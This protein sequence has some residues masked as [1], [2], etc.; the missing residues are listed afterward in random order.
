MQYG[1][2]DDQNFEYVI[3]KPDTPRPWTNYLGSTKYG[4]IITNHAGGFSF[5]KSAKNGR[6]IRFRANNIP[7]DQPGRYFYIRDQES[8]DFWSS[9]WQP[10]GKDLT[11]YMSICRHGTAYT[12][13]ESE[14]DHIFSESSYFVPLHKDYECWILKLVNKGNKKRKLAVFTY[15]EF[16]SHWNL[17]ADMLNLQYSQYIVNTKIIDNILDISIHNNLPFNDEAP[18]KNNSWH[19]FFTIIGAEITGYDTDREEV[20]GVY[21]GYHNPK[22]LF[23]G[24]CHNNTSQGDNACATM[25]VDIILKPGESKEFLVVMG[26]G[27]AQ[28]AGKEVV[29]SIRDVSDAGFELEKLKEY[30]HSMIGNF[31]TDTPDNNFNSTVNVWGAY[32]CLITYAWSRAASFVYQGERNGLGYRDTVQDMMGVLCNIPEEAVKRLELMI[33]GQ[34]RTG[35]ALPVVDPF[36]HFPGEMTAPGKYRSD[37]CL[38][39][40]NAVPEYVKET[41]DM[42]FYYKILP[43]ADEG[44]DTV[45]NHLKKALEFNLHLVGQNNLPCVMQADWNDCI[46]LGYKGESLFTAMQVSYGLKEY[47]DIC[48]RLNLPD[49]VQW[50]KKELTPLDKAILKTGWDGNWFIRGISE[51]G[52][53]HG[54]HNSEMA[55]IFLNPQCWSVLSNVGTRGQAIKAMDSVY[56]NLNTDYGIMLLAPPFKVINGRVIG[57]SLYND[58]QKENAGIFCHPQG[59]A[60]MAEAILGRGNRAYEYFFNFMPARMND[61]VEIRQIEP[62]VY[63]QSTHSKF[64]KRFGTSRLPWLSG[65]ASWA[66]YSATHYILGIRPEYDGL[67]IDPCLPENWDGFRVIRIFRGKTLTI[68]VDNSAGVEKGVKEIIINNEKI[69]GTKIHIE[70]MKDKNE[71]YVIM[72]LP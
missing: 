45:L 23:D 4:A 53:I 41:G 37:D 61:K 30:W 39:L 51:S 20:I 64:S 40:F 31:I 12:I 46:G 24:K 10:V 26:V 58:G 28:K 29:Q 19:S 59:W 65:T 7:M 33:T 18:D 57:A 52:E 3:N 72:Q 66:Y 9:S 54:S 8:G 35:G 50:A 70:K 56:E 2:F 16:A 5:Y 60:V 49:E 67:T 1:Y 14:Y 21:N 27:R 34:C 13:I 62:Y 47:I 17:E 36:H 55:K 15:A 44:E 43:Y 6:F 22:L 71:V 63:C 48:S 68:S 69:E 42:D 25:Q 32:N 38:W 11:Q